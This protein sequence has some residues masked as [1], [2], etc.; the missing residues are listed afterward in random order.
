M[1]GYGVEHLRPP[2]KPMNLSMRNRDSGGT[3]PRA[4]VIIQVGS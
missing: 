4:V 3:A 2:N 1:T